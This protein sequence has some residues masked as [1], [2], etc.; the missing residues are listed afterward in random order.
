MP[1]YEYHCP[2][3]NKVFEEWL[4]ISE[5]TETHPCPECGAEAQH[6][7]SHTSFLLKGGGW[8]VDDYGYRKGVKEDS[9]A[10]SAGG[11][12]AAPAAAASETKAEPAPKSEGAAEKKADTAPAAKSTE[13]K[14]APAKTE[15]K[16]A[17]SKP[18]ATA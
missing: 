6:I 8:Y 1:I 7:I 3:C 15:Q 4:K 17:G 14:P 13:S 12:S 2:K 11:S 10:S 5:L 9:D 16:S 18:A